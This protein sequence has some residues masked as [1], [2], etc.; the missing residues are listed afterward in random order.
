MD[1]QER[2]KKAIQEEKDR[3]HALW[4]KKGKTDYEILKASE[5]VDRLMNILYKLKKQS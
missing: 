2:L 3:L 4:D 1:K 5:K